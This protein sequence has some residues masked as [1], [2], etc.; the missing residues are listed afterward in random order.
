MNTRSR[1]PPATSAVASKATKSTRASKAKSKRPSRAKSNKVDTINRVQKRAPTGR[2][3]RGYVWIDEDSHTAGNT[4]RTASPDFIP[5]TPPPRHVIPETPPPSSRAE[6]HAEIAHLRRKLREPYRA[7]QRRSGRGDSE[8]DSSGSEDDSERG[9][10]PRV[11]F[12]HH[13]A[14]NKPFL[15]LY[16]HYPAVN[17]K[18]FKQI[19]WG[20]FQPG[21]SMRL[22]YDAL[23]WSTTPK[24]KKESE[25]ESSNMVQ[26]LRGFEV[27]A[28]AICFF[29]AR[30]HVALQLHEALVRY[31]VRL[32][33]FSLHYSFHSI[34]TYH[35]TF[36]G[37]RILTRQDDP[38]AWLSEDYECRHYL[39]PKTSQ[40]LQANIPGKT[41]APGGPSG[42]FL[43]Y[44]KFNTGECS[45]TNCKYPH[46]CSLC[47]HGHPAKDCRSRTA[48]TNS[49]SVPLG[50]RITAP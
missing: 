40:Q 12:L 42:G 9:D 10:R 17:I 23:A 26:L 13:H 11:S 1:A 7:R 25:P 24:G 47:Q 45:R 49:N 22:T 46:I 5:E 19:Y 8:D 34:R 14:G 21:Q 27:Y 4:S 28:H 33:D 31:R 15:R 43:S 38:V 48:A 44:N 37:K 32:M 16:E 29:A 39:V 41:S 20:T 6:L 36:M 18:Y 50:S 35:Y 3:A 30:P 2:N